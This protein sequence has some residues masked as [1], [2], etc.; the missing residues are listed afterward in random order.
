MREAYGV[1]PAWAVWMALVGSACAPMAREGS[2]AESAAGEHRFVMVEDVTLRPAML[3]VEDPGPSQSIAPKVRAVVDRRSG[4]VMYAAGDLSAPSDAPHAVILRR[5]LHEHAALLDL[6]DPDE[7]LVLERGPVRFLGSSIYRFRQVVG[8][9]PV[10]RRAVVVAVADDGSVRVLSGRTGSMRGHRGYD[11]ARVSA[12]RA[13]EVA[14]SAL[15]QAGQVKVLHVGEPRRVLIPDNA[16]LAWRLGVLVDA[17]EQG[18]RDPHAWLVTVDA[19]D[20][21]VLGMADTTRSC[22]DGQVGALVTSSEQVRL[23]M[24]GESGPVVREVE[25]CYSSYFDEYFLEDHRSDAAIFCYDAAGERDPMAVA[26]WY[27]M[28]SEPAC[29]S[30]SQPSNEWLSGA[31]AERATDFRN[32]QKVLRLFQDRF[33]RVGADGS[34]E[35]LIVA[36]GMSYDNARSMGMYRTIALGA[37][38]PAMGY[39]SYGV[40]DVIAHEF[41]HIV[42][43]HEW[44]G[45]FDYGLEGGVS[46]AERALDEHVA[47]MFGVIAVD[48]AADEPWVRDVR[49]AHAAEQHYR[50]NYLLR[51]VSNFH[52]MADAARNYYNATNGTTPCGHAS[53]IASGGG[54]TD[55]YTNAILLGRAVYL[56]TEG[57]FVDRDPYGVRLDGW[58]ADAPAYRVEGIGTDKMEKIV[59]H[60][61]TTGA[62]ATSV[63]VVGYDGITQEEDREAVR[64]QFEAVAHIELASCFEVARQERWPQTVCESVRAAYVGVGLLPDGAGEPGVPCEAD[65][66][67]MPCRSGRCFQ[68]ECVGGGAP[69]AL[70]G[71]L[72]SGGCE[73]GMAASG[74]GARQG[75]LAIA[76]GL[77]GLTARRRAGNR[78]RGTPGLQ[79]APVALAA[80]GPR[81]GA[82]RAV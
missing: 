69:A 67:G 60:A 9:V 14:S 35:N 37:G 32:A 18:R 24:E 39:P 11:S 26:V 53:Q 30:Y 78:R 4:R 38:N 55:A 50:T 80:R 6:T 8:D 21:V 40:V 12:D 71:G 17:G 70:S 13:R 1:G 64:E 19:Q 28:C 31:A 57:G 10:V 73:C 52:V 82:S 45:F 54:E 44:L 20:G 56:Y 74:S 25:T 29:Y 41:A 79:E 47:D 81:G 63:G 66:M 16:R 48:H 76:F 65:D 42:S 58:P 3:D 61:V 62:L 59:Y 43:W 33:G 2:V 34:G 27:S 46:G 22:T 23:A 7:E 75:W 77:M 72:V 36:S 51:T 15:R 68:G 5:F 49:W